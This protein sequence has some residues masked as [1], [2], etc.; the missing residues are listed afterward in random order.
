MKYIYKLA[1][2]DSWETCDSTTH[3]D[4]TSLHDRKRPPHGGI[5]DHVVPTAACLRPQGACLRAQISTALYH[6]Y[7]VCYLIVVTVSLGFPSGLPDFRAQ[8]QIQRDLSSFNR[9]HYSMDES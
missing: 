2:N 7:S 1:L 6:P 9:T 5:K 8:Y 3:A 4:H